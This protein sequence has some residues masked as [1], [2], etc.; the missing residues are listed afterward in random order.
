MER[1]AGTETPVS[2]FHRMA[3][4]IHSHVHRAQASTQ[5][6]MHG[7]G[8]AG[9]HGVDRMTDTRW[10]TCTQTGRDTAHLSHPG[11]NR[12]KPL[13]Y[14]DTQ[15]A[16][17]GIDSGR[18]GTAS[19]SLGPGVPTSSHVNVCAYKPQQQS[20]QTRSLHTYACPLPG[21]S[22]GCA[23]WGVGTAQVPRASSDLTG[24]MSV[25]S[26]RSGDRFGEK[27]QWGPG[28]GV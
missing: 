11:L 18:Q 27:L 1:W 23:V 25:A 28:S 22:L 24:I 2:Q 10:C 13:S 15:E 8:K 19:V 26:P 4:D 3:Y 14:R 20:G 6:Y 21:P 12:H 9:H 5:I 16:G 17:R 7:H